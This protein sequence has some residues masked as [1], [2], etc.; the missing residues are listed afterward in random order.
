MKITLDNAGKRYNR[1]WVFRK[2]TYHFE[3]GKS[4]ALLGPNG[5]GKST[6]IQIIACNQSPTEGTVQFTDG[7]KKIA[8]EDVFQHISLCAPYMQL[9]EEFTLAEQLSFH[10]NFKPAIEGFTVENVVQLLGM[11]KHARKQ[12]RY[13]SSGMKQRVKL[14][15][16]LLTD[17]PVI[18]LDEPATNL[19][20]AGIAWYHQLVSDYLKDRLL[21]VSSN[22]VEEYEMC[23]QRVLLT[24]YK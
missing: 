9:I 8:V 24:E 2:L 6:L 10:F 4:F 21:I 11:E 17:V 3:S 7:D 12:I 1:D 15:L 19:D 23:G 20:E 18:L 14:C 16:S 22:R 13:F 5:S